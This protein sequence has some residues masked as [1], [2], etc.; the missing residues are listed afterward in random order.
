MDIQ[1]IT[2]LISSVGFPIFCCIVLFKQNTELR[3]SIDRLREVIDKVLDKLN[4]EE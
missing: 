2:S 4:K 1:V 3:Q